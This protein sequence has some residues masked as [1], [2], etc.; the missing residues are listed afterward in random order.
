MR[1]RVY[2]QLWAQLIRDLMRVDTQETLALAVSIEDGMA[3]LR[4]DA[5]VEGPVRN[6]WSL[7]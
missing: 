5:I 1:S 6:G 3:L 7:R 4:V 2:L